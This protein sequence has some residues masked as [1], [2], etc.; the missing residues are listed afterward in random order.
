MPW[1][2][3]PAF[4]PSFL[5]A[6]EILMLPWAAGVLFHERELDWTSI[7]EEIATLVSRSEPPLPAK[8]AASW[9]I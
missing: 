7:A 3:P 2:P 8:R 1:P 6:P 5:V 9:N 4:R